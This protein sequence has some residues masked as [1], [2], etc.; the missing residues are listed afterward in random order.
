MRDAA[1]RRGQVDAE[2]A[3]RPEPGSGQQHR[4]AA[5]LEQRHRLAQE[6]LDLVAVE[7]HLGGL[8]FVE[9]DAVL[10]E[11]RLDLGQLPGEV[12]ARVA[13][14]EEREDLVALLV[15]ERGGQPES[16]VV[17]GVQ[18]QL[19]HERRPALVQVEAELPR[20]RGATAEA[21]VEP[22]GEPPVERRSSRRGAAAPGRG[23]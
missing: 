14:A 15:Q 10:G 6:E 7:L 18:P 3:R 19:E 13:R 12:A 16:R 2:L 23:R 17:L 4:D 21:V 8:G 1:A 5:R 22:A 20:S 9:A 11:Q